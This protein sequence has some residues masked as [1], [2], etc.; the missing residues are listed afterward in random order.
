M[1]S[2]LTA[3]SILFAGVLVGATGA[4]LLVARHY[5]HM[6]RGWHLTGVVE[7]AQIAKEIQLN[8]AEALAERIEASLPRYALDVESQYGRSEDAL[9]ALWSIRDFYES[10]AASIPVEVSDLLADLPQ[11]PA[12][13]SK[14]ERPVDLGA[15]R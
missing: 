4:T 15:F 13:C 1:R 9:V 8:R 3:I 7:Q 10:T 14:G 12:G 5:N 6:F 11:R 2:W